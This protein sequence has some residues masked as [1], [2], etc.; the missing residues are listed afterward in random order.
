MN[1]YHIE[2]PVDA[3]DLATVSRS[4]DA[5]VAVALSCDRQGH[6]SNCLCNGHGSAQASLGS[7][8]CFAE[9][10]DHWDFQRLRGSP[11]RFLAQPFLTAG[12]PM[13]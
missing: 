9:S 13:P 2:A 10:H 7:L 12:Q 8:Q 6:Y 3:G 1:A 4:L 5:S 11:L